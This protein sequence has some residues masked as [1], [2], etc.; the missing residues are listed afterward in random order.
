MWFAGVL[1]PKMVM[2]IVIFA[3]W[4]KSAFLMRIVLQ[5]TSCLGDAKSDNNSSWL[6]TFGSLCVHWKGGVRVINWVIRNTWFKFWFNLF[7]NQ[8]KLTHG[9]NLIYKIAFANT[10]CCWLRITNS[11]FQE[12]LWFSET[13]IKELG[14][15]NSAHRARI[16]SSLVA[17]R[18]K[19]ER[20]EFGMLCI[21]WLDTPAAF[22]YSPG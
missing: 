12:L 16:V 21:G 19:Y 11:W 22:N 8:E 7:C 18:A 9:S 1:G 6:S 14:V 15:R 20:G 13:D 4:F 3:H 2:E 17:L 5:I 10:L